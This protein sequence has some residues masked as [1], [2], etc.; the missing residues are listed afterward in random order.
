M[1]LTGDMILIGVVGVEA[2]VVVH[3]RTRRFDPDAEH[4]VALGVNGNLGGDAI[5][6]KMIATKETEKAHQLR[7]LHNSKDPIHRSSLC[8]R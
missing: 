3:A 8:C 6:A 4:V 1:L 2:K 5:A 7:Y